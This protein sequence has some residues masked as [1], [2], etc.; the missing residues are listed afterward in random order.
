VEGVLAEDVEWVVPK[1]GG[2]TTLRGIDEVLGWYQGGGV[3]DQGLPQGLGDADAI[4]V[5]EERGELE[6]FGDGRVGSVNR[7]VYT[8]KESG[9][10]AAV[11]TA[12]LAYTVRDGK[13]VRYELENLDDSGR[14]DG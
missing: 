6:D 14:N 10:V 13:I 11:K 4:D 12:R 8:R 1:G 5:A 9:E 2:V 3:A 7:V